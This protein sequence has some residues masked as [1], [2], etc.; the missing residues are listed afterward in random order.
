MEAPFFTFYFL[1]FNLSLTRNQQIQISILQIKT[2]AEVKI[3][4]CALEHVYAAA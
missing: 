1:L 4:K 3:G 2:L